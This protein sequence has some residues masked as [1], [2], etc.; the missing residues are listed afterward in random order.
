MFMG[1]DRNGRLG[2]VIIEDVERLDVVRLYEI[3]DLW[4]RTA[5]PRTQSDPP[6]YQKLH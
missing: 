5:R 6:I 2:N 4:S 1:L 3:T